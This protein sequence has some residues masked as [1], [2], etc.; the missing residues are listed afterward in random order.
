MPT[1]IVCSL[2]DL[3]NLSTWLEPI[4]PVQV[5]NRPKNNIVCPTRPRLNVLKA[6]IVLLLFF[7]LLKMLVTRRIANVDLILD[8]IFHLNGGNSLEL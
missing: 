7:Y 3:S 1:L 2:A 6:L 5:L 4:G 8:E